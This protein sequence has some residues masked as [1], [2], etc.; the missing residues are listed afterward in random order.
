MILKFPL[1]RRANFTDNHTDQVLGPVHSKVEE[2]RH[3]NKRFIKGCM[4]DTLHIARIFS[5]SEPVEPHINPFK[6][7]LAVALKEEANDRY[8]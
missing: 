5:S 2:F 8:L 3:S 7:R 4:I 1:Y 6:V